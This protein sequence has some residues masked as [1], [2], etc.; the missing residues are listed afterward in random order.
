MEKDELERKLE[1]LE[2]PNVSSEAHKRQ[3]KLTLLNARRTAWWGTLL[4]LLPALF[5]LSVFLKYELAL[6]FLFDPLDALIFAPIRQSSYKLIEPLLLF[7]IPLIALVINIM[8]ITHFSL[9]RTAAEVE[10]VV[11]IRRKWF[12]WAVIAISAGIVSV[13]FLY[14]VHGDK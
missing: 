7:V 14:A 1:N 2:R 9:D 11:S 12:N 4:V 6:G 3:L 5:L 8:A 10:L 13:I